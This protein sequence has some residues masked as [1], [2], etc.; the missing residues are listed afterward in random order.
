MIIEIVQSFITTNLVIIFRNLLYVYPLSVNY[1][2]R[3]TSARNIA[4]KVQFFAGEEMA[5]LEVRFSQ[6]G[7]GAHFQTR[8]NLILTLSKE[9]GFIVD[10][11]AS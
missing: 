5:P 9:P 10:Q 6:H 8:H 2:S 7:H 11:Q 1:T 4:I 3:S